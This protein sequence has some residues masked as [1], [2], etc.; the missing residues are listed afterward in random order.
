MFNKLY[1]KRLNVYFIALL[2]SGCSIVQLLPSSSCET[3]TYERVARNV[4]V[5]AEC[6]L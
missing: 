4:T 3:V 1:L 6:R 2:L 5:Y